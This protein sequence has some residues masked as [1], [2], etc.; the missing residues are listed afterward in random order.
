M[1]CVIVS[2]QSVLVFAEAAVVSVGFRWIR[3]VYPY[4]EKDFVRSLD[5]LML[6][7]NI[8]ITWHLKEIKFKLEI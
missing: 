8:N 2:K 3:N 1:C 6:Q 7:Q 5:C 4:S